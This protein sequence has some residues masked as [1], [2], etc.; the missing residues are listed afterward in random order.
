MAS[1]CIN[2]NDAGRPK[3]F[4]GKEEDFQPWAKKMEAFFAEKIKESAMMLEWAADQT[5]EITTE[6]INREFLPTTTNQE[7]GVQNLEFILQQIYTIFWTSRVAKQTTWLTTRG[8]THW[9]RGSDYRNDM[10]LPPEEG[11]GYPSQNHFSWMPSL[12]NFKRDL[13]AGVLCW[14]IREDE[15]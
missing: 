15:L 4:S 5:T 1:S 6:L 13:N 3:V 12:R 14:A 2:T 11:K 9:R 8:R 7:R 10:I